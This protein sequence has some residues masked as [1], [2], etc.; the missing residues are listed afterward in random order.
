LQRCQ[1][2]L[3]P[4]VVEQTVSMQAGSLATYILCTGRTVWAHGYI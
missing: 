3:I 2:Q 1:R 4:M